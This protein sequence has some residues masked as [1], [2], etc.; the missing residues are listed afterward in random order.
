MAPS[1]TRPPTSE[2][3][4]WHPLDLQTMRANT[5]RLLAEGAQLLSMEEVETLTLRLCGHIMVAV[6]EIEQMAAQLPGARPAAR[7]AEI[8]QQL[9]ATSLSRH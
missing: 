4:D 6:P 1:T 9:R 7:S 5:R 8:P 2:E 3:R